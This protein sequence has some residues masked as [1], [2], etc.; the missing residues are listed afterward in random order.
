MEYIKTLK[1]SLAANLN[2][3][4][5]YRTNRRIVVIESDDWGS[6]RMPSLTALN[7]LLS[8]KV[9][10]DLCYPFDLYDTLA[11][12]EDLS[13][14]FEVLCSVQDKNGSHAK[15][16]ANC[17]LANPVFQKIKDSDYT[18]YHYEVFTE[19]LEKYDS[20]SNAFLLWQKGMECNIFHPQYHGREHLN[21]PMWLNSL[22]KNHKGVRDSFEEGVFSMILDENED[23]RKHVLSAY[24]YKNRED[25]EFIEKSFQDGLKIFEDLFGY[26]S[27]SMIAPCYV[28]DEVV[29]N[30][31]FKNDIKYIQGNVFQAYPSFNK[32]KGKRHFMG[33]RNQ[34]NQIYLIRNCYFEP[35]SNEKTDCVSQCLKR[36]ET[37]FAWN[38]PAIISTHRMNFIGRL[39][40]R[41]RD[42]NLIMFRRLLKSIINQWS[43]VEF[44]FSDEFGDI[45]DNQ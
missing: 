9:D 3:I 1:S 39:D 42:D 12:Q 23:Q 8:K 30:I 27:K 34:N 5:G 26:K 4:R 19:T 40:K 21:V 25:I 37:A 16:T 33:E 28:W 17:I 24:N 15:I 45:I 44:L 29:E 32:K 10:L 6:I 22:K 18:E 7:R 43:D 41:N 13:S 20:H 36:I 31:A 11:S 35:S 14:L 2:N 38:K